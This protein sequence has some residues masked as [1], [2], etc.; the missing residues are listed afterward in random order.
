M[1]ALGTAKRSSRINGIGALLCPS[2]TAL[3]AAWIAFSRFSE[4]LRLIF[5]AK[6][7]CAT[8][9]FQNSRRELP[10]SMFE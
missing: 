4:A 2:L 1:A 8:V 7:H 10:W 6:G 3:V 9:S 5:L